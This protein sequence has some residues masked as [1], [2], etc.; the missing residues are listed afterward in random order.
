MR[1]LID[2]AQGARR[3]SMAEGIVHVGQRTAKVYH[4]TVYEEIWYFLSG[5]GVF[6]L[7]ALGAEMEEVMCVAP[8]DAILVSPGAGFW[9]ENVGSNDLVF[10]CCGS[11]PWPGDQEAQPW[12]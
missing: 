4:Q 12:P 8:G 1:P 9:V 6:H 7:H 10:L 5:A 3:L 11:P 2:R